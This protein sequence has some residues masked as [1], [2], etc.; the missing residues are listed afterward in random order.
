MQLIA[1][2]DVREILPRVQAPTLILDRPAALAMDSR[3]ARYFAEHIPGADLVELPGRDAI[4]FG[5]GFEAYLEAV[6]RFVTGAVV[7]RRE[8]RALATVLF[9]DICGSTEIAAERGD[10]D[11][12]EPAREPR[13]D[14]PRARRRLRRRRGQEHRR[15][16]PRDVRRPRPGGPLRGRARRTRRGTRASSS[17]PASTPARSR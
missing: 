8:E 14:H 1:R 12:R 11:W 2:M 5:D 3:H 15:R 6:E 16:L 13:P 17:A 7:N 10:R 9:T 4:S